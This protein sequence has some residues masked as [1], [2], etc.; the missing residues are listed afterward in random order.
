MGV[1][2]NSKDK[3]YAFKKKYFA[4][5]AL[6][7]FKSVKAIITWMGFYLSVYFLLSTFLRDNL[8]SACFK[9]FSLEWVNFLPTQ[10]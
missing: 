10:I 8:E 4:F 2:L 6:N 3:L 7:R 1:N 5:K 9:P